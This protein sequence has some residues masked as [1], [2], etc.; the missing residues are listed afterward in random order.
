MRAPGGARAVARAVALA[1]VL[2]SVVA[3]RGARA[4]EEGS[5]FERLNLDRLRLSSAGVAV[6]RAQ[7]SKMLPADVYAVAADYGEIVPRWR[8]V[9]TA[10]YWSTRFTDKVVRAFEDSLRRVIVDPSGD[11]TLHVGRV[12][13]SDIAVGADLRWSPL[14]GAARPYLGGGLLAHVINAEGRLIDG[15]F[16]ENALDNIAAGVSAVAGVDVTLAKH[17]GLGLE[18]R[19]DLTSGVRYGSVRAVGSYHFDIAPREGAPR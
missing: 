15:T 1:V 4:Q 7:P 18:A 10:T 16:V 12:R 11:D 5:L 2:A 14:A 6:G 3:A 13:V 17:L 19:Y 9:F 8:V